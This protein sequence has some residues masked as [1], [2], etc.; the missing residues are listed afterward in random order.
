M[1]SILL[2]QYTIIGVCIMLHNNIPV[3]VFCILKNTYTPRES[4]LLLPK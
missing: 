4:S 3:N 1:L 2:T